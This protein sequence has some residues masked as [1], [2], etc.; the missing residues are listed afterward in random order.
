MSAREKILLVEDNESIGFSIVE[1]LETEGYYVRWHTDGTEALKANAG[2]YHLI[3]LDLMLPGTY[4]L[5]I[6]KEYRRTHD[7]PVIILS[8]RGET[9]DKV[10]G[11]E[12]GADDYVSK[13]FFPRELLARVKSRLRRPLLQR[14]D[15]WTF[16]TLVIQPG[17]REVFVAEQPVSLTAAEY[18]LLVTLARRAGD[19]VTRS[20]LAEHT[21]DHE[22][23]SMERTLDTHVSRLR[24]KLGDEGERIETVWG[25]GYRLKAE[26]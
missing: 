24:K 22:R 8:A 12:L 11:L 23:N 20:E 17:A 13:P 14:G 26:G 16:G 2:A 7:T 18:D 4:G 19:A 21:L 1:L 3:I 10:R 6:L 15:T 5:D 25:I 9:D